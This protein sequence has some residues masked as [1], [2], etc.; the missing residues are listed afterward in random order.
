M[1]VNMGTAIAYL[2]LDTSKFTKGFKTALNDLK[3]FQSKSATIEQKLSGL[4]SSL[5]TMGGMLSKTVTLPIVG[6]GT[7]AVKAGNDFDVAMSQVA[8]TMGKTKDQIQEL[9]TFAMKMGATT[10]FSAKEAAEGLNV[11]AQSGLTAKEQMAALPDVLNL[12]AAGQLSLADAATYAI[13]SVKGFGDE[14]Q[15]ANKYVDLIAKG[16]TLANTD[17]R[18]LGAAL[19]SASASARTYG[20]TA[21]STTLSLLR[22]AEQNV[23]GEEAAT[24]LARAMMDLYTPTDVTKKALDELGLSVYD[25]SGKARDFNVVI[26]ELNGKL[27]G[28]SDEQKN[29][30][31]NTIFTT[32]GLSAFNK[33]VVSSTD[34]VNQFKDGLSDAS[35][36]AMQQA[37]TQLDNLKGD[38]TLLTSALEGAGIII[39][40]HIIPYLRRFVQGLTALIT[41]FNEASPAIQSLII[42]I[43]AIA[44]AVA[45]VMLVLSKFTKGLSLVVTALKKTTAYTQYAETINLINHGY[46]GLASKMSGIPSLTTK[47][48]TT[49]GSVTPVLLAGAGALAVVGVAFVDLMKNNED[50]RNKV[51]TIWSKVKVSFTDFVSELKNK[52]SELDIDFEKIKDTIKTVWEFIRDTIAAPVILNAF[53]TIANTIEGVLDTILGAVDIFVGLWNGDWKRVSDGVTETFNGI[54]GTISSF[55]SGLSSLIGDV[56]SNILSYFGLDKVAEKW[57]EIFSEKIPEYCSNLSDALTTFADDVN[58]FL[59]EKIPEAVDFCKTKLEAFKDRTYTLFTEDI[60]QAVESAKSTLE[61]FKDKAKTFFEDELPTAFNTFV[62][63]T[64]PNFVTSFETWFNELP[65]N[66]GYAIGQILGHIY[67]LGSSFLTWVTTDLP[68]IIDSIVKWFS[69]LPDR[70]KEWLDSVIEKIGEWI[71]NLRTKGNEAGKNFKDNVN[72]QVKELPNKVNT[73]LNNVIG[74]VKSWG[75]QMK[76]KAQE[77]ARNFVTGVITFIKDLPNKVWNII[78]QIPTKIKSVGAS[79]RTAGR[80]IFNK[81]WDGIK[82]VGSSILGWVS[83]FAGNI[84]SFVSGIVSGFK[85]VVSSANSAKS[86]AQSV[87]G[88]HASGL[89]YVPFNGYIAELHEGE[90]VLT[91]Q[92]NKEYNESGNTGGDTFVFYNTKPDAYEYARQ[93]KRAKQELLYT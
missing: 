70:I 55:V 42:K 44:A 18:G 48:V 90:R 19:S 88:R 21:E 23:T 67:N 54:V 43:A 7:A 81:L 50:F 2:E 26:D 12:A 89:D 86:A 16:A 1:A 83:D 41:K 72:T 32:Y 14:A 11:L 25:S 93:M 60:P 78:R 46:A 79:M 56:G 17:V 77:T 36:S 63:E 69:E 49:F 73:H 4:S 37:Q 80:E 91:K 59:K 82:S 28:M 33:M 65:Y 61:T 68:Q 30:Y 38:V 66:V 51:T 53:N 13:G 31:L 64:L 71:T 84:A 62:T 39:S 24:A 76:S 15:N 92:E 74:K 75:S 58:E 57:N 87:N 35:G 5:K 27:S 52:L 85:S 10:V 6:I 29:A 20:Q 8:A 34:K 22:L 47:I 45:P 3:A 40:D 9:R